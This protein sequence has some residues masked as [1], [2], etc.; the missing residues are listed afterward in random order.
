LTT[1]AVMLL[2]AS[3]NRLEGRFIVLGLLACVSYCLSDLSIKVLVDHFAFL[4]VLRGAVFATALSYIL[5]GIVGVAAVAVY[6]K[7]STPA[8]WLYA[9]PFAISWFVA[10]IFLFSCFGLVGVVYG[11]ILQSVRGM[12]SIGLG[13]IIAH[14]GFETLESRPTQRIIAQRLA[15]AVLMV[16]AVVLFLK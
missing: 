16:A 10:M 8:T 12:I 9:V 1:A 2:S 14:L 15:A 11:N 5:C 13:F 3:G 7:H 4:G 6:P